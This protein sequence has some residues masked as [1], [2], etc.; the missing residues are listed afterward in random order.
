[1]SKKKKT[2][3]EM[4]RWA[5]EKKDMTQTDL[6]HALGITNAAS[7]Q[8]MVSKWERDTAFPETHV[9]GLIEVLGL[10]KKV[11]GEMVLVHLSC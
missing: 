5:R 1:M 2:M 9:L 11:V 10:P 7:A 8:V 3:G 6:G 4:I